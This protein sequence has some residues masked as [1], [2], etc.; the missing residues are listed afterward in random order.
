[1]QSFGYT[2]LSTEVAEGCPVS[3]FDQKLQD[4]D[5]Q[6]ATVLQ[7]RSNDSSSWWSPGNAMTISV[8]VLVFGLLV[9]GLTGYLL[10]TA[11]DPQ[12]V[13]K[14]IGLILVVVMAVFLVVAG[15]SDKQIAPVI[16]LLG[17]VLGYLLG[18]DTT[19]SKP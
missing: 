8:A 12:Q 18:K 14:V 6:I 13:P 1:L 10:K 9:L 17:T 3:D 15:Y 16:G 19:G 4:L 11:K 2:L 7:S 5:Q